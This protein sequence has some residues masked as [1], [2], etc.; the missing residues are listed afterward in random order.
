MWLPISSHLIPTPISLPSHFE[1]TGGPK[2]ALE[3]FDQLRAVAASSSNGLA[4]DFVSFCVA[5]HCHALIGDVDGARSTLQELLE[6]GHTPNH[7]VYNCILEACA[8]V[9]CQ[10][11]VWF[12]RVKGKEEEREVPENNET[13]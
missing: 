12:F 9:R 7:I 4:P 10:E 8:K 5:L 3:I 11:V 13:A 6:A 1:Q 2:K